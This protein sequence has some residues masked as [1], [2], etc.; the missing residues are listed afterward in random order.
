MSTEVSER[1]KSDLKQQE[2]N[3]TQGKKIKGLEEEEEEPQKY[4][5]EIGQSTT[6]MKTINKKIKEYINKYQTTIVKLMC[7]QLKIM[8][9]DGIWCKKKNLVWGRMIILK[10]I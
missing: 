4:E 1:T 5:Y 7:L 2:Q 6:V 10:P 8:F 3:D 9:V